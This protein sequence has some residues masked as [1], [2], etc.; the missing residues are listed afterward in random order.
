MSCAL[1]QAFGERAAALEVRI[2]EEFDVR[3]FLPLCFDL[4][5]IEV[6]LGNKVVDE[7]AGPLRQQVV[8]FAAVTPLGFRSVSVAHKNIV[9]IISKEFHASGAV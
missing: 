8:P 5:Q 9:R 7:A 6:D 4:T 3:L 1:P 2:H